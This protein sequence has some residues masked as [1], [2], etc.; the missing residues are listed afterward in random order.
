MPRRRKNRRAERLEALLLDIVRQIEG[1]GDLYLLVNLRNRIIQERSLR[2]ALMRMRKKA[3]AE[4][5]QR[6]NN[7]NSQ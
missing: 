1:N 5:K 4:R 6:D 2:P 3:A 7:R